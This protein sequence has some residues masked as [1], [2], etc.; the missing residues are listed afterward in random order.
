MNEDFDKKRYWLDAMLAF[1]LT[2]ALLFL[3][4]LILKSAFFEPMV[5]VLMAPAFA[6]ES[7]LA[8]GPEWIQSILRDVHPFIEL[9]LIFMF[10]YGFWTLIWF[11][12]LR[13]LRKL[14]SILKQSI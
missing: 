3:V 11:I 4:L 6:F 2:G 12:I 10:I 7:V 9:I 1:V 14:S 8:D 5:D 13:G